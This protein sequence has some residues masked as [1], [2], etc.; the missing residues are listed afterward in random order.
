MPGLSGE[1]K[2]L[3]NGAEQSEPRDLSIPEI[4]EESGSLSP[5]QLIPCGGHWRPRPA[6]WKPLRNF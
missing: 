6:D 2:A 3:S 4:V 1:E 5:D